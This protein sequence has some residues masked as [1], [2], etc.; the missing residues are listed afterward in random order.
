M[1]TGYKKF[2]EVSRQKSYQTVFLMIGIYNTS[3]GPTMA[4]CIIT[5]LL[6]M[7]PSL[8]VLVTRL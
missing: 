6:S 3:A 7:I 2:I 4:V 8:I 5:V 1:I